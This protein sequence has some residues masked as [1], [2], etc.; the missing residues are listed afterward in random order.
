MNNEFH[1]WDSYGCGAKNGLLL[2][3][4]NDCSLIDI[5]LMRFVGHLYALS[6]MDECKWCKFLQM[7][8]FNLF[9]FIYEISK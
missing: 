5:F 1:M 9:T 3:V 8:S 2:M 7:F 6:W 4:I